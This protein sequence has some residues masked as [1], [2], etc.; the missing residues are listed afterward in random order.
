V[1]GEPV[2][3][4]CLQDLAPTLLHLLEAPPDP[5]M[6][7]RV[8]AES[9]RPELRRQVFEPVGVAEAAAIVGAEDD[10]DPSAMLQRLKDL[11]YLD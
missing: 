3:G 9:L 7:G 8:L 10:E 5:D 4:A 11:G 6:D 1:S 2:E